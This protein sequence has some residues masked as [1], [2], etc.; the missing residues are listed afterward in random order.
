MRIVV[1]S[2]TNG[3]RISRN[4]CLLTYTHNQG[5]CQFL[6]LG[7][8][9]LCAWRATLDGVVV[10]LN[11]WKITDLARLRAFEGR[12]VGSISLQASE[13]RS[14]ELLGGEAENFPILG[15]LFGKSMISF[16]LGASLKFDSLVPLLVLT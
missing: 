4:K 1:S 15:L 9:D 6:F 8:L 16:T 7:I 13:T 10:F 11:F 2:G 3:V 12:C 14:R 5:L